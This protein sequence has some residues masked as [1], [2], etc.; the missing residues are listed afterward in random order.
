MGRSVAVGICDRWK[1]GCDT[2]HVTCDTWFFSTP[3]SARKVTKSAKKT[4]SKWLRSAHK[5]RKVSKRR[6]FIV[7][8]LLF[9]KRVS[10]SCIQNFFSLFKFTYLSSNLC[11]CTLLCALF[12]VTFA[13]WS[14]QGKRL[15]LSIIASEWSLFAAVPGN[16]LN[17]ILCNPSKHEIEPQDLQSVTHLHCF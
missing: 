3:K 1:V 13:R 9:A 5:F 8:V 4:V 15:H 2:L 14:V 11:P 12:N 10:V 7:S 17:C 6:D 16:L